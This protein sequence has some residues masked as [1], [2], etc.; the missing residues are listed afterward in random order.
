[1]PVWDGNSTWNSF[2]AFAWEGT[3]GGRVLVSV[4]YAPHDSQCFV[5]LPFPDMAGHSVRF[6]DLMSFAVYD[7][8]GSELLSR[9]LY[10]DMQSW[11]YHVFEVSIPAKLSS[12]E[13][14]AETETKTT[15]KIKSVSG[16]KRTESTK[17][18]RRKF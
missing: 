4:N 9:G 10:L 2:I 16:R 1:V 11:G 8:D 12:A 7:R 18:V 6:K 5:H 14:D 3:D 17:N 13:V 15:K